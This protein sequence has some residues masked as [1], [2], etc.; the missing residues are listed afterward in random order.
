MRECVSQHSCYEVFVFL[1]FF[2]FCL[3]LLSISIHNSY[4]RCVL[5]YYSPVLMTCVK[6]AVAKSTVPSN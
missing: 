5:S 6:S 4:N 1:F 2:F 3:F